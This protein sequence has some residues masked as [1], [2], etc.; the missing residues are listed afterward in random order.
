[1]AGAAVKSGKMLDMTGSTDGNNTAHDT[2]DESVRPFTIDTPQELLDDLRQ[3]L[4]HTRWPDQIPGTGWTYGTDLAYLQSFCESWEQFDWRA[5][6]ARFNQWPQVLTTID[7]QQVHA[8]HA[9][10][11]EP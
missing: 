8:I 3:R 9:R 2:G 6:E 4:A 11:P 5:V 7:G 1:M 10:S